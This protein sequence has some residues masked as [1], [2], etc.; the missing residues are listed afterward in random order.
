MKYSVMKDMKE[1]KKN[2]H[3][4]KDGRY[5][6]EM[7][8]FENDN[9]DCI[10]EFDDLEAAREFAKKQK[11]LQQDLGSNLMR[12]EYVYIA[13]NDE[14]GEP[15]YECWNLYVPG[16]LYP[17]RLNNDVDEAGAV[18]V[19]VTTKRGNFRNLHTDYIGDYLGDSLQD[20][21][22][23]EYEINENIYWEVLDA[24]EYGRTILANC[25]DDP[26]DFVCEDTGK[27]VVVQVLQIEK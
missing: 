10:G 12:Y 9:P 5:Q 8:S 17:A 7:I 19:Y 3:C 18:E 25:D 1:V 27:I 16:A 13:E 2:G 26:E 6:L 4:Y 20:I 11:M 21:P 14:D 23:G 15:S 22:G 24:E